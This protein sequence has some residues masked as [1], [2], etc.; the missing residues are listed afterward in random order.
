MSDEKPL[1][2]S[3]PETLLRLSDL[4]TFLNSFKVKSL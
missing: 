4:W 3:I 2:S 1:I